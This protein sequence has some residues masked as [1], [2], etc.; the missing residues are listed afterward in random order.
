MTLATIELRNITKKFEQGSELIQVIHDISKLFVQ[1]STYAI[2]GESGSGKSTLLHLIA[3]LSE[4]SSGSVLYN[5][6]DI[7]SIPQT[8]RNLY[9]NQSIGLLFQLPYLIHELSVIENI[10]LKGLIKGNS[11]QESITT[12]YELLDAVQLGDKAHAHP[13]TLSGG[14]QQRV[15]LARA[16]FNKPAFLLADEPTGNLD[17]ATKISI[18]NFLHL[19]QKQWGMGMIISTHDAYV[20]Q[21]MQCILRLHNGQFTTA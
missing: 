17:E 2:T 18:V 9:L 11:Y 7:T 8:E 15:A 12:A 6:Q 21:S 13:A 16:L 19:C 14:Q 10:A 5:N 4:P 20:A 3:G 1:S